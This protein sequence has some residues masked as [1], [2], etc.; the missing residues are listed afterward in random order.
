MLEKSMLVEAPSWPCLVALTQA[1]SLAT[2]CFVKAFILQKA[3]F[4]PPDMTELMA[5]AECTI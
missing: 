4:P 2:W 1:I 5:I 3:A